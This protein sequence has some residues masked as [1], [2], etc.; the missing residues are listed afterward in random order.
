MAKSMRK[1][2]LYA[3]IIL[4][5]DAALSRVIQAVA[6]EDVNFFLDVLVLIGIITACLGAFSGRFYGYDQFIRNYAPETLDQAGNPHSMN[7]NLPL[8]LGGAAVLVIG[9]V[10]RML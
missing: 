3:L 6:K 4:A 5:V 10:I 8:L 7:M 2:L 9:V 1:T